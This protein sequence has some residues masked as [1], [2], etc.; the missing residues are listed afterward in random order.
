M[1]FPLLALLPLVCAAPAALLERA[2]KPVYWLLAGDST[3]APAGGWGD[4]FLSTTVAAGSSDYNW[5][6]S[7]ATTKSFRDGGYWTSVI[8]DVKKYKSSYSVYVTIQVSLCAIM[9]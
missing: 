3:T 6:K 2:A 9:C 4:A 1:R 8:N 5:A 7:G